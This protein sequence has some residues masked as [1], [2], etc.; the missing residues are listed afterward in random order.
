MDRNAS[1]KSIAHQWNPDG[2]PDD[3]IEEAILQIKLA[4]E[5]KRW[6]VMVERI[7]QHLVASKDFRD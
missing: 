5:A 7:N 2:N 3:G 1:R 4:K 6:D